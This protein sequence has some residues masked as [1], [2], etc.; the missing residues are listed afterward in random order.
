LALSGCA[1]GTTVQSDGSSTRHY[2]GY[3]AVTMPRPDGKVY[4]S[5]TSAIG[6][7]V[8]NGVGVGYL[9]DRMVVVPLDCRMVLLVA[10][11][12]QYDDAIR[13]FHELGAQVSACAALDRSMAGVEDAR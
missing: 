9:R 12:R 3:V 1:L 11:Q 5:E 4:S 10:T 6:I 7:R 8:D 13:R 2:F